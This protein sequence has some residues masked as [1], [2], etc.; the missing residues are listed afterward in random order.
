MKKRIVHIITKLELGG[1]QQNTLYTCKKLN[2]DKYEVFLMSGPEGYLIKEA[3]NIEHVK[4]IPVPSMERPLSPIKDFKALLEIRKELKKIKPHLVHT[5][6]SKAGIL[7]RWGAWLAGVPV[8]IH[9]IHGFAFHPFMNRIKR[10]IYIRAEKL[11]AQITTKFIAV[12]RS[13]INKGINNGIFKEGRCQIIRSG[14]DIALFRDATTDR[15]KKL[16]ELGIEDTKKIVCMVACLKPQKAPLDFVKVARFVKEDHPDAQFLL[17]G[18]G[19]LRPDVEEAVSSYGLKDSFYL[20]GW[21]EDIP[22]ILKSVDI[23]VLTSLW[24]GLPRVFAQAIAAGLP[25]VGTEVDG[26]NEI[27][28]DT[29]DGFLLSPGDIRGFADTIIQLLD[30]PAMREEMG[31]AG[32]DYIGEFDIDIMVKKQE[33]LYD[34]LLGSFN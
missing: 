8:I 5:H 24:E 6:S 20:P 18:D 25:V 31:K 22:E 30:N 3:L 28:H 15:K 23:F 12:A 16:L 4:F 21:R 9:S 14:I 29:I 10:S 19:E 33:Q 26:A 27:I 32:Q 1:A 34:S 2:Q 13:N 17:V 7:G 11:T